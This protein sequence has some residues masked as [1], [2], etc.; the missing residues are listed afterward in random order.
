MLRE[1][2]TYW[3]CTDRNCGKT[4]LCNQTECESET[5]TCA[6]GSGMKKVAQATVFSYLNFLQETG[7]NE[8]GKKEEEQ[9]PCDRSLWAEQPCGEKLRWS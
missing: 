4:Q 9:T 8:T 6:C 7:S 1:P 2:G 3:L 5:R